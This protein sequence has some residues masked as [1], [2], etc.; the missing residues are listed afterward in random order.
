MM[1]SGLKCYICG[2]QHAD[3]HW[4][5]VST[6]QADFLF[7]CP[8]CHGIFGAGTEAQVRAVIT[9]HTPGAPTVATGQARPYAVLIINSVHG[10]YRITGTFDSATQIALSQ[11]LEFRDHTV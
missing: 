2:A 1:N 11:T 10:T 7:G 4:L 5:S 9:P 8:D 3:G 6:D